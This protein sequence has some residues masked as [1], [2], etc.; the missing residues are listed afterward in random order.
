MF[1][2][3]FYEKKKLSKECFLY[4]DPPYCSTEHYYQGLFTP[5]DHQ[6]LIEIMI[7]SPFNIMLSIGG[8]C[9]LY[10]EKLK[11]W[12]IQEVFV[13]YSTDA[14]TQK[15]SKEYL[16][17]NYDIKNTPIMKMS[18]EQKNLQKYVEV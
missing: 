18:S 12:N 13:R 17:M 6:D 3:A 8:D 4:L 9:D 5:E 15:K 14:N 16:I 7:N 10:L 2:R 11:D 1:H